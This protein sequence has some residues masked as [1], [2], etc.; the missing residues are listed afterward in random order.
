MSCKTFIKWVVMDA[1]KLRVIDVIMIQIVEKT[2]KNVII[3]V[4]A[5]GFA[6]GT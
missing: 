4:I 1:E 2:F 5:N 6:V 3:I